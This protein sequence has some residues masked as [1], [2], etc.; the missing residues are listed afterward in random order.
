MARAVDLGERVLM[1]A[2]RYG[3]PRPTVEM[4]AAIIQERGRAGAETS[5][6]A[7]EEALKRIVPVEQTLG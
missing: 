5:R 7:A 6:L 3:L 4:L 2:T 1:S